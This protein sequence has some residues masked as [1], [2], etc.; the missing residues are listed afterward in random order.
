MPGGKS[1]SFF[2]SCFSKRKSMPSHESPSS[3]PL[4]QQKDAITIQRR[5]NGWKAVPYILGIESITKMATYGLQTNFMVYLVREY[6]MDQVSAAYILNIWTGVYCLL[7]VVGASVAD[8]YLG[9]FLT[10]ALASLASLLGM[11]TI[12]MTAFVPLL[13]PPPCILDGQKHLVQCVSNTK[14][15]LGFL[16]AGL[17]LLAIGTGGIAPCSI[18]FSVDQFDSTTMEG[19]KSVHSFLNWYYASSTVIMLINQ[20]LVVYIQDSVSWALGFGIPTLLI[21]SVI[22]LFLAGSK[23]YHHVKPE[24]T[25]FISFAQVLVAAYKKRHLKL[26]NDERVCGVFLDVS[27]DGNVVLS[28]HSLTTK[29]SSLKKAALVVDD[30]LKDDGSCANSWKLCSIQQVEEVICFMKILPIWASGGICFM[31]SAQEGT[32]VVSQALKMDRH[33]GP[34]FEMPAGS[35]KVM[36]LITLCLCIPLYNRVLQPALRKITKHENGITTLQRIGLGY[37]FSILFAVVAGLVEQQRRAS[38]L[39][40]AS[41]DGVAPLSVFWLFPQLMFLGM[42][43][44]F[45]FVGHIELYNKEFPEKMRSIGNSLI[46]LCIAGAT[47][48]STLVVSIVYSVTGKH[49]EPNWLDNDINAGRLDYFYI[50]I[51]ALGVLNFAY[52]WSCACGYT[53]TSSLKAVESKEADILV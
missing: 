3:E 37:L 6:H 34:N 30:D 31:T 43:E 28:K 41:A 10:I 24:G 48:L 44:L 39:S 51:A 5:K 9:K 19:R 2:S 25:T 14:T 16:L 35:I 52:F 23:I 17:S 33:I 45:G 20:T 8:I 26:H 53:Y 46:Y 42:V 18:P 4:L 1:S 21:L 40:Q 32:F 7:T 50:L 29:F 13:R 22:P 27:S 47:Y 49:G 11:V 15:Q 12:T 38:A 36:S